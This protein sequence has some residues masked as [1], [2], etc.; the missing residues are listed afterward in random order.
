MSNNAQENKALFQARYVLTELGVETRFTA[1]GDALRGSIDLSLQ[2]PL[3]NPVSGESIPHL[4]FTIEANGFLRVD[5]PPP[6]RGRRT[7]ISNLISLDRLVEHL[8]ATLVERVSRVSA[9]C[10]QL[11]RIG[12]DTSMD[13]ERVTGLL[14]ISMQ[15]EGTVMLEI[16]EH[17]L[18]ARS[19]VPGM[20]DTSPLPLGNLRFEL[21]TIDDCS[22]LEI[23]LAEPVARA[24]KERPRN[25]PQPTREISLDTPVAKR[26]PVPKPRSDLPPSLQQLATHFGSTAFPKPGFTIGRQFLLEGRE[27]RFIANHTKGSHFHVTLRG[28]AEVLWR[29]EIELD[30]MGNVEDWVTGIL[31]CRPQVQAVDDGLVADAADSQLSMIA[32]LLPPIPNECWVMDVRIEDDDGSE[33]RYR[34]LNVGGKT[35]GAPRIL[36][37]PFFEASYLSSGNGFRMLIRVLDVTDTSVTYQ[38]LDSARAPVG[39]PRESTLVVFLANFISESAAY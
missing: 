11:Q 39:T 19:L 25:S 30:Q 13:A 15:P 17:G 22:D 34:G 8:G 20:G 36:P 18:V 6:L 26:A 31:G 2:A 35:F 28:Q 33:V 7:N 32:G 10:E 27:I 29:G 4:A 16:D 21:D 14:R 12:L 23:A 1:R 3:R 5:D 24:L 38:R 9:H 37:K